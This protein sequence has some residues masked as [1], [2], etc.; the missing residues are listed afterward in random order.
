M[1]RTQILTSVPVHHVRIEARVWMELT[2]TRASVRWAITTATV[3]H[4]S[5]QI[6][7]SNDILGSIYTLTR[8]HNGQSLFSCR[9]V[10]EHVISRQ[11]G[12]RRVE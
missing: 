12:S 6:S 9:K 3:K 4:V 1:L 5:L 11:A 8:E 2:C 10:N 7:Q